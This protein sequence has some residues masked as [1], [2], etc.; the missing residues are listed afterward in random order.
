[1]TTEAKREYNRL[2]SREW[3][4]RNPEK[5][6]A[7]N[8]QW[9]LKPGNA[10]RHRLMTRNGH[11]RREWDL[12]PEQYEAMLRAQNGRCAMCGAFPKRYRLAI[13]HDHRTGQVRGLL[14]IR[15]N[16]WLGGFEGERLRQAQ[17]Y[18]AKHASSL[19]RSL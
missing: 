3:N 12:T 15:C 9:R 19:A 8:R 17:E 5:R 4:T 16:W 1:M 18:L 6:K 2:Y 13:D 14:C 11:L 10:D 7:L